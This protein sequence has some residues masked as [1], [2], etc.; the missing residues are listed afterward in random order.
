MNF[1]PNQ[2]ETLNL[3][4]PIKINRRHFKITSSKLP[5]DFFINQNSHRNYFTPFSCHKNDFDMS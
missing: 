4:N 2:Q 3:V 5:S 1:F